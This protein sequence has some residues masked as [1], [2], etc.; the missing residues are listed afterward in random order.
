MTS[1]SLRRLQR[2][3]QISFLLLVSFETFIF[4]CV[5]YKLY[6][7]AK[8]NAFNLTQGSINNLF[9]VGSSFAVLCNGTNTMVQPNTNPSSLSQISFTSNE[10]DLFFA[11]DV[12]E[13]PE[14]AEIIPPSG[15]LVYILIF[16]C[17][18]RVVRCCKT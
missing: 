7:V 14:V 18:V 6:V 1:L 17:C 3:L 5:V 10:S 12:P 15:Q 8:P 4:S 11:D 2:R 13:L 16:F 9:F